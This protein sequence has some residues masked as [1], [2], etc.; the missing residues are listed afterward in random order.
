[1]SAKLVLYTSE[2]CGLCVHAKEALAALGLSYDEV[3]VPDEH[4]YRLRTPVL[5]AGGRV[6]AE[7]QIDEFALRRA[8]K[9]ALDTDIA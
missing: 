4:G 3:L 8:L 2:N 6:V 5:E 1:M 9:G 7:G